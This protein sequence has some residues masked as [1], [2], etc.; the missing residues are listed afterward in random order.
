MSGCANRRGRSFFLGSQ[1]S[2]FAKPL[3]LANDAGEVFVLHTLAIA[4]LKRKSR[5][6]NQSPI[7]SAKYLPLRLCGERVWLNADC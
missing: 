4:V 2:A 7:P 5:S 1:L 3:P 6:F